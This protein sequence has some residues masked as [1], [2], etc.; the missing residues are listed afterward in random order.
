M[1]PIAASEA[2]LT[3][4]RRISINPC[5]MKGGNIA[6][7]KKAGLLYHDIHPVIDAVPVTVKG[8]LNLASS[9]FGMA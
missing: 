2:P 6:F 8:G 1:G 7:V 3:R 5:H 9:G 4:R